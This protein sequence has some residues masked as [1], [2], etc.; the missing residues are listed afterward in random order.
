M[1]ETGSTKVHV[2][3]CRI[4]EWAQCKS[5]ANLLMNREAQQEELFLLPVEGLKLEDES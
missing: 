3:E 1:Y 4:H 5:G 2:Q